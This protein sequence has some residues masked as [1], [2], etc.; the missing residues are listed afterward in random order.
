MEEIIE[1]SFL[2]VFP[3]LQIYVVLRNTHQNVVATEKHIELKTFFKQ[4]PSHF[5]GILLKKSK[6]ME[7]DQWRNRK[8]KQNATEKKMRIIKIRWQVSKAPTYT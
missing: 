7:D 6:D 2:G 5:Q 1:P 3:L 8:K 4:I